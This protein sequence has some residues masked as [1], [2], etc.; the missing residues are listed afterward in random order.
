MK[1]L[2]RT[3]GLLCSDRTISQMDFWLEMHRKLYAQYSNARNFNSLPFKLSLKAPSR[4][5]NCASP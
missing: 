3:V 4:V 2:W 5:A 1:L